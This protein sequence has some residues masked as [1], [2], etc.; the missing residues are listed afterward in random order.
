M[1][2]NHGTGHGVG[3]LLSVHE[4]PQRLHWRLREGDPIVPLEPGMITSDEPGLYLEGK[5]GIRH[6]NLLLTVE[7]EQD[8]RF[9]KFEAL[10]LVPFDR[11]AI[12][13]SLLTD[14]EL[15]LLNAYHARVYQMIA[16]HLP[17]EEEEW[18][19][20]ATAVIA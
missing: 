17:A 10:T 14:W 3:Y 9:L 18:L 8:D 12:D 11:E 5:F 15:G 20:E 13:V 1:D 7:D 16:P 6:E 19:R 2:F 4:G